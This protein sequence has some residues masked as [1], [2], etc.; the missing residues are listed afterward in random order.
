MT[1]PQIYQHSDRYG[2]AI[3]KLVEFVR[4]YD[5]AHPDDLKTSLIMIIGDELGVW[6]M[7]CFNGQDDG[8]AI[9]A[10]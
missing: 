1:E 9:F 2:S 3:D 6:P 10:V 4:S 8:E 5:P 7:S